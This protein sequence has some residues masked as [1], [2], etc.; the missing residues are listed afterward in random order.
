[1]KK[2]LI[3]SLAAFS[4]VGLSG[5]DMIK[6]LL[7]KDEGIKY[8]GFVNEFRNVVN[9]DFVRAV[10]TDATTAPETKKTYF[11][12]KETHD[13][14]YTMIVNVEGQNIEI[15]VKKHF[16]AYYYAMELKETADSKGQDI[17][18]VWKFAKNEDGT[19]TVSMKANTDEENLTINFRSNGLMDSMKGKAQSNE[20][21]LAISYV[22]NYYTTLD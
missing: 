3:L 19:F 20:G 14:V 15:P 12:D 9:T 22:Y 16:E 1:M 17:D 18:E 5:C 11:Y 6:G 2:L 10:E 7:K 13:W 4:M 21:A 8:E